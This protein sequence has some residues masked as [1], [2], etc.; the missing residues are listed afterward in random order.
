MS[1]IDSRESPISPDPPDPPPGWLVARFLRCSSAYDLRV[2]RVA[3]TRLAERNREMCRGRRA[4]LI[5]CYMREIE[6]R[7]ERVEAT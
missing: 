6:I 7:L 2:E 5:V 4:G 3:P 1:M